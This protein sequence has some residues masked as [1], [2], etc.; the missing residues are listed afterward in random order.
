[1]E[2]RVEKDSVLGY[3]PDGA[4]WAT[5]QPTKTNAKAKDEIQDTDYLPWRS[6]AS[7]SLSLGSNVAID[8][9]VN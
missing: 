8:H 5:A 7:P 9:Y 3:L 6:I 4:H 2:R 1:M